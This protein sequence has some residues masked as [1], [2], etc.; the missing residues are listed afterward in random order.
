MVTRCYKF[1][2]GL[3]VQSLHAIH[4][5]YQE[6]VCRL[7]F[8]D[9]DSDWHQLQ[10]VFS[11]EQELDLLTTLSCFWRHEFIFRQ[12]AV[13]SAVRWGG[14]C[15]LCPRVASWTE[16]LSGGLT[17]RSVLFLFC[18]FSGDWTSSTQRFYATF[19][20]VCHNPC[21]LSE[22]LSFNGRMNP[23]RS[24]STCTPA[25]ASSCACPRVQAHTLYSLVCIAA[26]GSETHALKFFGSEAVR[27]RRAV[28]QHLH[29][30]TLRCIAD[31]HPRARASCLKRKSIARGR[32][33]LFLIT[34]SIPTPV[35]AVHSILYSPS[36]L[37]TH[38][39]CPCQ[40][41][42]YSV[43]GRHRV[44]CPKTS[45]SIRVP[46]RPFSSFFLSIKARGAG[47]RASTT[48]CG[49]LP[50]EQNLGPSSSPELLQLE[51]VDHSTSVGSLWA[52][53][54]CACIVFSW[55]FVHVFLSSAEWSVC[56]T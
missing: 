27:V 51:I 44:A 40:M 29:G 14:L 45:L 2:R 41:L 25:P 16:K 38:L 17:V 23:L 3:Q 42:F 15:T 49:H 18:C 10:F 34:N 13:A 8:I 30:I 20:F 35:N 4:Q 56:R 21:F 9:H 26:A 43:S 36:F 33:F 32:L 31:A 48:K 28:S 39:L 24:K 55:D 53:L 52:F 5:N 46:I 6:R 11:V 19:Y 22:L 1:I 47:P 37:F 7:I 12:E 54:F 50:S